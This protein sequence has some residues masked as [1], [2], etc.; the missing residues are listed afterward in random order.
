MSDLVVQVKEKISSGWLIRYQPRVFYLVGVP[1]SHVRLCGGTAGSRLAALDRRF[2]VVGRGSA[3]NPRDIDGLVF[4]TDL[5]GGSE[6][7]NVEDGD[8]GEHDLL[9]GPA[10]A[11]PTIWLGC[12]TQATSP[13]GTCAQPA[14]PRTTRP[15]KPLKRSEGRL[16]L[17]RCITSAITS[18]PLP[19]NVQF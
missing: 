3:A 6:L 5:L 15:P 18:N 9:R 13:A 7:A 2:P 12:C 11:P 17:R 10:K 16:N 19:R 4:E 1:G 14:K 8:V